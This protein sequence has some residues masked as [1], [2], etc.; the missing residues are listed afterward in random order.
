[1]NQHRHAT[2]TLQ[3][4]SGKTVVLSDAWYAGEGTGTQK[5]PIS[6]CASRANTKRRKFKG[7]QANG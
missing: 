6:A 3:L 7:K 5:R 1:M 4:A 2:V